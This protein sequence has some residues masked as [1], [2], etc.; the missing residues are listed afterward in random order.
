M[1]S[2]FPN[3]I[4]GMM[5]LFGALTSTQLSIFS[6]EP[7]INSDFTDQFSNQEDKELLDQTV[8]KLKSSGER[9]KEIKLSNNE[10]VTI[11]VD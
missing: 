11:I 5:Y 4:E 2:L 1:K 6:K 10:R 7:L 9:K 3:F 8:M